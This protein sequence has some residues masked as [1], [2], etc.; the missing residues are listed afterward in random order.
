MST[1]YPVLY[2]RPINKWKVT[3]LKEELKRRNLM[4]KGL[5][6]DLVRRLDEAIRSERSNLEAQGQTNMHHINEPLGQDGASYNALLNL[7]VHVQRD[8]DVFK[9]P[10]SDHSHLKHD[11][12][13][14]AQ[15]KDDNEAIV[16]SYTIGTDMVDGTSQSDEGRTDGASVPFSSLV[17]SGVVGSS[18][19]TSNNMD[20]LLSNPIAQSEDLHGNSGVT[21][22][23]SVLGYEQADSLVEADRLETSL[24]SGG[25]Q[26]ELGGQQVVTSSDNIKNSI[27]EA[28]NEHI[29]VVPSAAGEKVVVSPGTELGDEYLKP[30]QMNATSQVTH[31]SNQVYEVSSNLGFQVHYE[32][33]TT[34]NNITISNIE[35]TEINENLN[36]NNFKLEPKVVRQETV[37]SSSR[38]DSS[39]DDSFFASEVKAPDVKEDLVVEADDKH[40]MISSEKTYSA[41]D[42]SVLDQIK[43]NR[44]PDQV[45]G[46]NELDQL[47]SAAN[48]NLDDAHNPDVPLERMDPS[49]DEKLD[50]A[51][52]S[53]GQLL[54]GG[55]LEKINL[56]QSS[57]DDSVDDDMMETKHTDS[58]FNQSKVGDE[59]KLTEEIVMN[60]ADSVTAA[61]QADTPANIPYSSDAN[62]D[63]MPPSSEKR[64]FEVEPA[65]ENNET[66]KRQRRWSE[67]KVKMPEQRGSDVS[68]SKVSV[69]DPSVDGSKLTEGDNERVVPPS[70]KAP[71]NS[72][73]I[74]NFLRPFTLKAVQELLSRTGTYSAFWMDNI[75][76]HCYVTVTC[77][78]F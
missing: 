59:I 70:S 20:K 52:S 37:Q 7:G 25:F 4:V 57:A 34:D 32:S 60:A 35:K 49:L 62:D 18:D 21:K 16:E 75:K 12:Q 14:A 11:V 46:D 26:S 53:E 76:T 23:K 36:D 74:D 55:P 28:E 2:D 41:D 10:L 43:E 63:R 38:K 68:L 56:D 69:M 78:F 77:L 71:T 47:S 58:D 67:G 3:E 1:Q 51:V 8:S 6:D 31:P 13:I 45:A 54:D 27:A 66:R 48:T 50:V 9:E 29:E 19:G 15:K 42:V 39:G 72:L 64:K 5:K 33:I 24:Q 22:E 61:V 73:R 17:G 30:I 44:G 65:P 40:N